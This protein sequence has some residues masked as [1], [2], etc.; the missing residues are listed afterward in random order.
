MNQTSPIPRYELFVEEVNL[1][2]TWSRAV[3]PSLLEKAWSLRS[4]LIVGDRLAYSVIQV[5]NAL[6][7]HYIC[8]SQI[9]LLD[10]DNPSVSFTHPPSMNSSLI[11][12]AP[13]RI[14]FCYCSLQPT[15]RKESIKYVVQSMVFFSI[16]PASL[17]S[18]TVSGQ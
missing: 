3:Y 8:L 13:S 4:H 10:I 7:A 5:A 6:R 14:E 2:R 15:D 1:I 18:V 11:N 9:M 17:S 16:P 12:M